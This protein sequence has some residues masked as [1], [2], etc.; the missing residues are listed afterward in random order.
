MKSSK[1]LVALVVPLLVSILPASAMI[2]QTTVPANQVG[3][4]ENGADVI[5]QKGSIVYARSGS[6]VQ[7]WPGSTLIPASQAKNIPDCSKSSVTASGKQE[8]MVGA[9]AQA[10]TAGDTA[11]IAFEGATVIYDDNVPLIRRPVRRR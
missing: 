9:G 4:G 1:F 5:A 8:L 10:C 3:T 2:P 6:N 7:Y 11:V